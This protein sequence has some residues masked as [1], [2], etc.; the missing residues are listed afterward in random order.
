MAVEYYNYPEPKEIMTLYEKI[1]D[2]VSNV[3]HMQAFLTEITTVF[4]PQTYHAQP[5]LKDM[6]VHLCETIADLMNSIPIEAEVSLTTTIHQEAKALFDRIVQFK[7]RLAASL[8]RRPIQYG[9]HKKRKIKN[10]HFSSVIKYVWH[11]GRIATGSKSAWFKPISIETEEILEELRG[12]ADHLSLAGETNALRRELHD[13]EHLS[14]ATKENY[15]ASL[16]ITGSYISGITGAVLTIGRIVGVS[17]ISTA[18][19]W[20][21][22]TVGP[23]P[24]LL[25]VHMLSKKFRL[26]TQLEQ[27]LDVKIKEATSDKQLAGLIRVRMIVKQVK[28]ITGARMS[29]SGLAAVALPLG[30]TGI[31]SA[32]PIALAGG[33]LAIAIGSTV[34]LIAVEY[35]NRFYLESKLGQYVCEAFREEIME[36]YEEFK[37]PLNNSKAKQ[38]QEREIWEYVAKEFLHKYR[39]DAVF[40][41]NR[42]GSILQY[43]QSGLVYV[44][45]GQL[46]LEEPPSA[47]ET[48]ALIPAAAAVPSSAVQAA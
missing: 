25:S 16:I 38:L 13:F 11:N 10:N 40:A 12:F 45:D 26:L 32:I 46:V 28:F 1:R 48:E 4:I 15:K 14:L 37:L 41:G 5:Y 17:G 31:P 2:N 7:A 22:A 18:A 43:I 19:A 34:A 6:L 24:A 9:W 39:F 36:L 23:I 8:E 27:C 3:E 42:Y 29:A 47:N 20:A 33:A 35:K 21:F 30:V 44:E